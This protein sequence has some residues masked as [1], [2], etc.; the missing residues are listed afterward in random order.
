MIAGFM[1]LQTYGIRGDL[2]T[3][4]LNPGQIFFTEMR[5]N[6]SLSS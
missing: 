3:F 4:F 5:E 1:M 2:T 6:L